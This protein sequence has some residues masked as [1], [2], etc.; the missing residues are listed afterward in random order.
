MKKPSTLKL[1]ETNRIKRNKG[2]PSDFEERKKNYDELKSLR[3]SL[4][5][6]KQDKVEAV[7]RFKFISNYQF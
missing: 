3:Q 5:V 1:K 4:K 7:M 6:K 2:V